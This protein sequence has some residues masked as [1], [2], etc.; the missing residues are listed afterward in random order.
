MTHYSVD[1]GTV[2]VLNRAI[3]PDGETYTEICGYADVPDPSKPGELLVHFPFS[4]AGDYWVLDT[5]YDNFVSIYSCQ[6]ILSI[7]KI[8]FAWILVRDPNNVSE[9]TMNR[10]LEAFTKNGLSTVAF[11]VVSQKD[12]TYV[13][14]SGRPSCVP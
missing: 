12:C 8:E 11:E 10:A 5:D 3:K 9:E 7:V 14:P 6:D 4:P 2:G 1:D 13:D